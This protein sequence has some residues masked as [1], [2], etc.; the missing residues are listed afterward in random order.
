MLVEERQEREAERRSKERAREPNP[1]RQ[2]QAEDFESRLFRGTSE[3]RAPSMS[4][5]GV[6]AAR[7]DG[8]STGVIRKR[9]PIEPTPEAPQEERGARKRERGSSADPGV[10]RAVPPPT[11][12]NG[13][14]N[15]PRDAGRPAE[16]TPK[17]K[18][19]ENRPPEGV[20]PRRTSPPRRILTR[21]I[22]FGGLVAIP[23][24]KAV[25]TEEGNCFNCRGSGHRR[26]QCPWAR[27]NP[28]CHNCGRRW[29]NMTTCPRC[30][31]TYLL[32][33]SG[34]RSTDPRVQLKSA[35]PKPSTATLPPEEV[36]TPSQRRNSLRREGPIASRDT[37]V[38][39]ESGTSSHITGVAS[40]DPVR[41]GVS[42]GD[43]AGALTP[44]VPPPTSA[45][46]EERRAQRTLEIL[47][48]IEHLPAEMQ[49]KVLEGTFGN[50][51]AP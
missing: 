41:E 19:R 2:F 9:R 11:S 45:M 22:I 40:G 46:L 29:V 28:F 33:R 16:L 50:S 4:G 44:E 15:P 51:A 18:E 21:G 42:S 39:P 12:D 20:R 49:A 1:R 7:P 32:R 47:R 43:N 10:P 36:G 31:K 34:R 38:V 14:T 30:A 17:E 24:D 13:L 37:R 5:E 25:D 6:A 48:R 8:V 26:S 35:G 23:F 3:P 27:G